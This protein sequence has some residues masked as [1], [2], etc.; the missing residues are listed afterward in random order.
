MLIRKRRIPVLHMLLIGMLP[1]FLKK[2]VYRMKGYS[3]GKGVSLSLGSV[4]IG[5]KVE[6][7]DQTKIGFLTIIRGREIVIKR[8]VKIG[9][10]SVID[11]EKVFIDDDARLNEQV[12]IG[13]MRTPTSSFHLGKR[14]IVMQLSYINPTLPVFIDDDSG[15]GGHCLLFT[16]GSWNSQ[17][18][19]YPVRFAPIHIGKKVWLPWRVFIMPGVTIGDNVVIGANSMISTDLPS[20]CFAAGSPAKVIKQN[21]PV[22]PEENVQQEMLKNIF[23]EFFEFLRYEEFKCDI[24][25]TEH[26]FVAT[27][28]GARSGGIHYSSAQNIPDKG[29]HNTILI[30]FNADEA[31]LKESIKRGFG[32]AV[33]ITKR[34]RIGSTASGEE[35]LTFFSRYGLRFDRLD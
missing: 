5:R 12:Y 13:G 6:I 28:S 9:S 24:H 31:V 23:K 22:L 15:I 20:N 8:F 18:E 1:S 14:A 19:G 4:I 7:G 3:I 33:S 29:E 34:M 21:V 30:L 2:I 25:D 26:G 27:V 32:M 10:M 35:M 16:H 11:T 17:I